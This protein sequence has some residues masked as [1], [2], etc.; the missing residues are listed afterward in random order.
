MWQARYLISISLLL[1]IYLTTVDAANPDSGKEIFK[2]CTQCHSTEGWGAS[3]GGYPQL[4]GQ[5][6]SVIEKQIRDIAAGRRDN[7]KMLPIAEQLI[8]MGPQALADVAAYISLLKM[9]PSPDVGEAEDE[10]LEMAAQIN[11]AH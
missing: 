10:Q 1:L 4:A 11:L 3:D 5:H 2:L 9:N 8:A 7:P 6:Q